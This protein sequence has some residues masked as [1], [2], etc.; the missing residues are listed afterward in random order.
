MIVARVLI[1][2]VAVVA[3]VVAKGGCVAWMTVVIGVFVGG[4][5]IV[6]VKVL[7]REGIVGGVVVDVGMVI[8][9]RDIV[10]FGE[11]FFNGRDFNV[12]VLVEK[13][14]SDCIVK[15]TPVEDR[16]KCI[17]SVTDKGNCGRWQIG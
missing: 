12:V 5:V 6:V 1:V 7:V 9:V 14:G 4:G 13:I 2:I 10:F 3:Q 15:D 11:F 17:D 8:I 16:A